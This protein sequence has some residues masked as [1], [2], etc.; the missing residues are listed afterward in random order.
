MPTTT[1]ILD[2]VSKVGIVVGSSVTAT[3]PEFCKDVDVVLP[4]GRKTFK[5]LCEKWPND[6][7]SVITGH[8]VVRADPVNVEFLEDRICVLAKDAHKREH[9]LAYTTL[10]RKAGWVE[11]F[12]VKIRALQTII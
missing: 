4:I 8:L 5:D 1:E 11:L 7:D 6:L 9:V 2:F 10:R 12:G 3:H